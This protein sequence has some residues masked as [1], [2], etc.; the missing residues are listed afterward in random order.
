MKRSYFMEFTIDIDTGGTF[1][2]GFFVREKEVRTVKVPTTP[3]DLTVCFL[4]CVKEGARQFGIDIHQ[5]LLNT[6]IIRYSNTIG[7][8]TII[9]RTGAKLGLIVTRGNENTLYRKSKV[10]FEENGIRTFISEGMISGIEEAIDEKGQVVKPVNPDEVLEKAQFLIDQGARA[11]VVSLK[12]SW[13]NP[14]HEKEVK[15]IIKKEYPNF[16]LGSATVFLSS[17]VIDRPDDALRTN[18]ALVNAYIHGML[19][20]Y[21]YKAEEDLRRN[22]FFRPLMVVHSNGGV[23]RVAKTRAINTYSSGPVAGLMGAAF[24]S[25]L[26]GYQNLIT[27]DMGGTSFDIGIILNGTYSFNMT[28]IVGGLPINLP[29]IEIETLGMGGGS[30]AKVDPKKKELK[31]GP[32]SAGA[33]P[34]PAAFD[35]GGREATVTD[36]DIV[37]GFID[38]NYFLG[39]RMKLNKKR[40]S[41]AIQDRIG[42]P[43]RLNLEEAAKE[44][45]SR[46]DQMIAKEVEK[47]F[48]AKA[49]KKGMLNDM[50]LMVYGGA[51]PTHCCA[52]ADLL[53]IEKILTTPFSPV[54]SAFGSSIMDVLH[55]YS[56]T[57]PTLLF[58]GK[59]YTNPFSFLNERIEHLRTI[60]FR[61]MRGEG[62][63]PEKIEIYLEFFMSYRG[64]KEEIKLKLPYL[65]FQTKEDL[66]K[67]YKDFVKEHRRLH[68]NIDC[69]GKPIMLMTLG[70]GVLAPT[71]H[72]QISEFPFQGEKPDKALK[73]EREVFWRKDGYEKTQIY[74]REKL[75][76]GNKILGPAIIEARDTTYVVPAGWELNVDRYKN[77]M[78][79]R[80]RK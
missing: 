42:T 23:A 49:G 51:G 19:V 75:G 13:L 54:F 29:M 36:S 44:I 4:E 34:G 66:E 68:P 17:E 21:L 63:S 26:Y 52:F 39:G 10:S 30:I 22:F 69:S 70:L 28:P 33:L 9:Q 50:V 61:D 15:K 38:P 31:V 79:Q 37:L 73:G 11:I 46:A 20:K 80:V 74:D 41:E 62:F 16:Y 47:A 5:M 25:K 40:A 58:D 56:E 64:D 78:I 71:P 35:L 77:G 27:T 24:L 65:Q 55:L 59:E 7:T 48:A 67:I 14:I 3:H 8:N 72:F 32:E 45:K 76:V 57:K 60:A 53:G 2:D 43:L 6:N 12:N 1:T 18:N